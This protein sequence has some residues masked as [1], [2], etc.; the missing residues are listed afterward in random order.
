MRMK[1]AIRHATETEPRFRLQFLRPRFWGIWGWLLL[2][3]LSLLLPRRWVMVLGGWLGDYLRQRNHKRRRIAEINLRL[4][5]PQWSA[6]QRERLLVDHF[7]Q[8]GRGLLDMALVLWASPAR[9]AKV[10]NLPQREWL[11]TTMQHNRTLLVTYHLTTM[12]IIG[13]VLAGLHPSV[14][15]M[16]RARNPLLTWQLWKGRI[17]HD[18]RNIKLLMRDQGLRTLVRLMKRGRACLF[19]PDEDFGTSKRTVFAPF[20]GVQTCTLTTVSRLAKLTGALVIPG[21]AQLDPRSGRY[22]FKLG[23]PL[24]N[25]PSNDAQADAAALNQA[26]E[27]LIRLA[28]AQYTWTFRWF[29][30]QPHGKPSPYS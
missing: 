28:P 22:T 29:K 1:S 5:F 13:S 7:R 14:S 25:F 12:D 2:L 24:E 18:T 16:K 17:H 15:M 6:S 4:C 10:C 21:T 27:T 19:V 9:L 26:M 8:Y 30:A 20:F 23:A 11:R 3:R